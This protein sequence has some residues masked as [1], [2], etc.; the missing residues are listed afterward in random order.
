MG[1]LAT[2]RA[3]LELLYFAS[4][5]AIAV[6]AFLG[7]KQIKLG[8]EQLK[9]TKEIAR[10][11]AKRE[12]VKFASDQARYF[13]EVCSPLGAKMWEEYRQK[14]FVY[15]NPPQRQPPFI[16]QQGEIV[17]Q[18]F[19]LKALNEEFPKSETIVEFLNSLE[20]FAIP[21]AAGLADEDIGF[22]EGARPFCQGVLQTMPA[23]FYL[24]QNQLGR[25][26]SAVK[27]YEI[28]SRRLT[29]EV[30]APAMKALDE[31]KKAGSQRIRP[32]DHNF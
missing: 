20:A 19:D 3:I 24:R 9:I 29:A 15:L 11:N 13:A 1:W 28:W 27:L 10:T 22:S 31:L 16:V 8:L 32:L 5:V 30:A 23:L 21:F 7:L 17:S 12:S 26:E 4:S 14:H 6:F 25:Y 18:N 2:T